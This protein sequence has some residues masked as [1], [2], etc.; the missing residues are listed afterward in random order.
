MFT[1]FCQS[2]GKEE[3][4]PSEPYKVCPE[5]FHIFHTPEALLADANIERLQITPSSEN[6]TLITDTEAVLS[7]PHCVHD[8]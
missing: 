4:C 3:V 6:V 2:H 7:C 1:I 8:F 5:C